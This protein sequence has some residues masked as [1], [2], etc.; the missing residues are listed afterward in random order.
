M[1]TQIQKLI[2]KRINNG[3]QGILIIMIINLILI[4]YN[5][6][7]EGNHSGSGSSGSSSDSGSNQKQQ[8]QEQKQEQKNS[9]TEIYFITGFIFLFLAIIYLI[10]IIKNKIRKNN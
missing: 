7:P 4:Y 10:K 6:A 3:G 9:A 8:K 1:A 5:S 2:S